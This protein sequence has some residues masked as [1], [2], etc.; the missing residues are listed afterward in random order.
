MT[1]GPARESGTIEVGDGLEAEWIEKLK[2][3][4]SGQLTRTD[5]Q[6]CIIVHG[7]WV[8]SVV[9]QSSCPNRGR[10][11]YCTGLDS[12]VETDTDEVGLPT[13]GTTPQIQAGPRDPNGT[14]RSLGT[15]RPFERCLLS[16]LDQR[17]D[18]ASIQR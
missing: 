12:E 9:A 4:R 5:F 17:K 16:S 2:R 15:Y 8:L 1:V 3:T 18:I 10:K 13:L 7:G 14:A 11:P 6:T